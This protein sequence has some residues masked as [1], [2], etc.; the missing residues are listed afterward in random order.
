[1]DT[2]NTILGNEIDGE[3]EA[4]YSVDADW[5]DNNA[6]D[7]ED[8]VIFANTSNGKN[9]IV[10]T[11]NSGGM[12]FSQ[13]VI[14]AG[15]GDVAGWIDWNRNGEFDAADKSNQIKCENGT[16][17]LIWMLPDDAVRSVEGDPD[18][19]PTYMRVRITNQENPDGSIVDIPAKG[20][21]TT[22]G[23]VEDYKVDVELPRY[24]EIIVQKMLV[25]SDAP[26]GTIEGAVPAGDDWEF[27]VPEDWTPEQGVSITPENVTT[28]ENGQAA[29]TATYSGST[30][31]GNIAL[32]E[33]QQPGY[34]VVPVESK[35]AV[36][37]DVSTDRTVGV[38]GY[39]GTQSHPGFDFETTQGQSV[40]CTIYNKKLS[41]DLSWNK[42]AAEATD[43]FLAGSEWK[44]S[45]LDE[46]GSPITAQEIA[47][48]DCESAP[49]AGP[50]MNAA[51][52]KFQLKDIAPGEYQLE[53][54]KAPAGYE[55][56]TDPIIVTVENS[57]IDLGDIEN[58]QAEVPQ[59]PL[60]GGM[61]TLAIF[62]GA[63]GI[64]VLLLIALTLQRRRSR[65]SIG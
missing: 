25:P 62:L 46:N 31:G 54:T 56:L 49:C 65:V 22:S 57:H 8:G 27:G 2:P 37:V 58:E 26:E 9:T 6:V 59:L 24:S 35:N 53:E 18:S 19:A 17:E 38:G 3:L 39:E 20:L 51:S 14:C 23:E 5:D 47:I 1:M 44:L 40:L 4:H 61:G 48:I 32:A 64:G 60:T 43:E 42:V 36:C 11:E 50:D 10:P 15:P 63:G 45:P 41:Y 13:S 21:T 52:G 29:F 12:T 33:V 16:A 30:A 28:D 34:A 55:L 7:D